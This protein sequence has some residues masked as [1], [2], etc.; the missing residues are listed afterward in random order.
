MTLYDLVKLTS[1]LPTHERARRSKVLGVKPRK[2]FQR[3]SFVVKGGELWS[4]S[5]GW[6]TTILYPKL[7]EED[8]K[9]NSGITPMDSEALVFCTCPAFLYWGS[10][11]WSTQDDYNIKVHKED[12]P[13]YVRDPNKLRYVCKHVIRASRYLKKKSFHSLN[14]QFYKKTSSLASL[15]YDIKP[16]MSEFMRMKGYPDDEIQDIMFNI[17]ADNMDDI[18]E[19]VGVYPEYQNNSDNASIIDQCIMGEIL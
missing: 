2:N 12:R 11:Y 5:K 15:E 8:S 19:E 18:L 7:T 4:S 14:E 9:R 3:F 6:I 10:K 17:N 13:P 1:Y 16:A